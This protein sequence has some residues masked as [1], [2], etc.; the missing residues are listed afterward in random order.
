M[1]IKTNSR[2]NSRIEKHESDHAFVRRPI[3]QRDIRTGAQADE[4]ER[5]A[6]TQIVKVIERF[7]NIFETSR[8]WVQ[9]AIATAA[10][11]DS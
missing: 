6:K 7:G 2:R 4:N 9:D 3:T 11:A 1:G 10:I 8:S 5:A